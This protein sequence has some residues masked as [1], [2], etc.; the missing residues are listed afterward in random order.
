VIIHLASGSGAR[1]ERAIAAIRA[2]DGAALM[3]EL[4]ESG[5]LTAA[6]SRAEALVAEA[7]RELRSVPAGEARDALDA[8][9]IAVVQRDF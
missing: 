8:A 4:I 9:A 5:S 6:R 7:R 2:R 1:R 3:G